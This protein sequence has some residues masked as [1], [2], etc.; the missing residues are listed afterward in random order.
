MPY[1]L[2][3]PLHGLQNKILL[4]RALILNLPLPGSNPTVPLPDMTRYPK[5]GE[6]RGR[7]KICYDKLPTEGQK[8]FK[9]VKEWSNQKVIAKLSI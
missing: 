3:R 1:A 6:A 4:K 9:V 5:M 8:K 2:S 7:C